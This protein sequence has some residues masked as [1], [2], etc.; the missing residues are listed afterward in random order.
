MLPTPLFVATLVAVSVLKPVSASR[1]S[2]LVESRTPGW[3]PER[4]WLLPML[5]V[6]APARAT[7]PKTSAL[8][9][10]HAA[11]PERLIAG[12]TGLVGQK[13]PERPWRVPAEATIGVPEPPLTAR[14]FPLSNVTPEPLPVLDM[15]RE[16]PTPAAY[17]T[18][19]AR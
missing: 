13:V 10:K 14:K 6:E 7:W 8:V 15:T 3:L 19:S 5:K 1:M 12:V 11:L 17:A 9:R 16:R 4:I 2:P 18:L